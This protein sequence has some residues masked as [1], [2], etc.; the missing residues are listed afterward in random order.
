MVKKFIVFLLVGVLGLIVITNK[1]NAQTPGFI[2]EPSFGSSSIFDP[3]GDGFVSQSSLG[4]SND[5]YDV[6][7]FEI[8]MFPIPSL[9]DG[10]P[11]SDLAS[12]PTCGFT[13]ISFD[14]EG[15]SVYAAI[16]NLD[17]LLFRYRLS[18]AAPNAKGYSVL[19][20]T[21]GLMGSE[22]PNS[23]T[24]NPGFEI[25]ITLI[26]KFGVYIYDVDGL[27]DCS[28]E[29]KVYAG[30]VNYQKVSTIVGPCGAQDVFYD[31]FVPFA[32]LTTYFGITTATPIRFIATT[33]TSASCAFQGSLSDIG[34]VDDESYAGCQTCAM[35]ELTS[36][37]PPIPVDSLC[38]TC[39]GFSPIFSEC[40]TISQPIA[41]GASTI[42]GTAEANSKVYYFIYNSS[43]TL[44]Y[45]D[46]VTADGDG[47]WVSNAIVPVV[48]SG[49][50]VVVGALTP[51]KTKNENCSFAISGQSCTSPPLDNGSITA[52]VKGMCAKAGNAFNGAEIRIY[53]N[54]ALQIPGSGSPSPVIAAADGSWIWKCNNNS[55]CSGGPNCLANGV[56]FV[57]QQL[58]GSCE[59]EPTIVCFNTT[60]ITTTPVIA[61]PVNSADVSVSGKAAANASVYFYINGILNSTVTANGAGNWTATGLSLNKCD[62][63]NARSISGA[64]CISNY[65]TT[66]TVSESS[67]APTI[68][69]NNVYND[70][71]ATGDGIGDLSDTVFVSVYDVST[72]TV[73]SDTAYLTAFNNWALSLSQPLDIGDSIKVKLLPTCGLLSAFSNTCIIPDTTSRPVL[74]CSLNYVEGDT[75]ISGTHPTDGVKVNV[76]IDGDLID[77]TIVAGGVWSITIDSSTLYTGGKLNATADDGKNGV[78]SFSNSCKVSCRLP[79]NTYTLSYSGS[80]VFQNFTATVNLSGSE[81]GVFYE[82]HDAVN[83]V[84]IGTTTFG[85]GSAL[86]LGTFAL[87]DTSDITVRAFK[88]PPVCEVFIPDTV[89]INVVIPEIIA[90]DDTISI[91]KNNSVVIPVLNNDTVINS[92]FDFTSV[93]IISGFGPYHGTPTVN[94]G[95]GEIT[96]TADFGY[97][98]FDS[99]LYEVCDLSGK[100]DTAML[101]ITILNANN[102]PIAINDNT[103]TAEN[104]AVVIDVQSND[105]DVDG[106]LITTSLLNAPA[107]GVLTLLNGD[108]I[109]Y[110]PNPSY[111][112]PD[113]FTYVVCDP[114]SACDT[115]TVTLFVTTQEICNNGVDDD[116][117]GLSDCFDPD[118]QTTKAEP[119]L[120]STPFVCSGDT[121]LTYSV[122]P[123]PN[124]TNYTWTVPTGSVITSGQGTQTITIN[125]GPIQGQ[126][127][128]TAD[129]SGCVAATECEDF[130]IAN[131]QPTCSPI[132][133]LN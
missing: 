38:I 68:N 121:G 23:T 3:N 32:D 72:S 89:T 103:I 81:T 58:P 36:S 22:D 122:N 21:D 17:N 104:T 57:T 118:C 4:F 112:G 65:S 94:Y 35:E 16:D 92:T 63:L 117:D 114:F 70:S 64:L 40:P 88:L 84:P 82:L 115:A 14:T 86:N 124:A 55:G 99:L 41:D 43:G 27:D 29:M 75:I 7:E 30:K 26:T 9:A 28:A 131:R 44:I 25:A 39:S 73:I 66:I 1:S 15:E 46:S 95:T 74:D 126:I 106:D 10:E 120:S 98:G 76:F 13:D 113:V 97:F 12:G 45:E 61:S 110:T 19:I 34:G 31:F 71:Y 62:T 6:D 50:S 67:S 8:T 93:N 119:I 85:T 100:C 24:E 129:V 128:V 107:N 18:S 83:N 54:G 48:A 77:T 59:S 130:D 80:E 47:V 108:S 53:L 11:I 101:R 127:C 79:I 132:K 109:Q 125:W 87:Q 52:S 96:Y 111:Y 49:D 91:N 51:G 116:L 56:Y 90:V 20:D 5:G 105:T 42:D 37:I 33:N 102:A 60:G 133:R 2:F 69:C 78:S 123:V